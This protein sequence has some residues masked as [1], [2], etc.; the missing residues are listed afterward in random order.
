MKLSEKSY[1]RYHIRI[2]SHDR[3]DS[4]IKIFCIFVEEIDQLAID[5]LTID[6]LTVDQL[7]IDQFQSNPNVKI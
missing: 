2:K 7:T 6:Q 3:P 4:L 1:L 5:Q